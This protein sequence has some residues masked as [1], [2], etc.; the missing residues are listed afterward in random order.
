[1]TERESIA[2]HLSWC[3][4]ELHDEPP[5]QSVFPSGG[6]AGSLKATTQV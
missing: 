2:F 1:M 6:A 4:P 5:E 3:L